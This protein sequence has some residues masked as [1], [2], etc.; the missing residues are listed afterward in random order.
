MYFRQLAQDGF[1]DIESRISHISCMISEDTGIV[2]HALLK[3]AMA[4]RRPFIVRNLDRWTS[5]A[6]RPSKME[7]TFMI[8]SSESTER[9]VAV[10]SGSHQTMG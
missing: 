7:R 4:A 5:V 2:K 3:V 6:A 1:F 9:A 10:S 8:Q